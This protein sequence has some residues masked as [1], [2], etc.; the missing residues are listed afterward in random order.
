MATVTALTRF[1]VVTSTRLLRCRRA[2]HGV[3]SCGLPQ[4]KLLG[5]ITELRLN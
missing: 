4:V 3:G 2:V 1:M 5:E